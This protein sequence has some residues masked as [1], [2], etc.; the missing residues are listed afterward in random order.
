MGLKERRERE[1]EYRRNQILDAARLLL[2]KK[3]AM[4]TSVNQISKVSEL[5]VGTI[6][7]YFK[8]KEEIFAVLQEE[9]LELLYAK[10]RRAVSKE[11]TAEERL[12]KIALVYLS[13]SEKNK[14]YFDIINYFL[15]SAEM[16]FRPELKDRIDGCADRILQY[17]E[18]VING[19][20][21]QGVFFE[22]NPRRYSIM[23][24][25]TIHGLIRIKKMENTILKN[26]DYMGLY[27]F[28]VDR[29]VEGLK[30]NVKD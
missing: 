19:G 28:S 13:F 17:V 7:F 10:I 2:F 25:A 16:F 27:H 29:I 18:S 1:K 15:S 5:A 23:F 11:K 22:E 21:E 30:A 26:E 9:G 20:M 14:D 4:A 3:G 24:W 12:K 8:S 6:Y